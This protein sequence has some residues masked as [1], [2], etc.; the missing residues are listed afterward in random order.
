MKPR[1]K[2]IGLKYKEQKIT[3][4]NKKKKESTKMMIV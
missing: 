4:Q 2:I 3:Y 1:I